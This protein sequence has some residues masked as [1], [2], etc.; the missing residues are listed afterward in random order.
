M[1]TPEQFASTSRWIVREHKGHAAH[2]LLDLLTNDVLRD[3]GYGEGIA[4]FESA[5]AE[6]HSAAHPY[7]YSGPC[8]DCEG[9]SDG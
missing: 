6:W 8:P 2:K 5:V 1:I 3:L 9:K 7:P 4:V